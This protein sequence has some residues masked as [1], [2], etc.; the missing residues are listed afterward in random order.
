MSAFVVL[1]I[2]FV[3]L[4]YWFKNFRYQNN[5]STSL[6]PVLVEEKELKESYV[7]AS[8]SEPVSLEIPSINLTAQFENPLGLAPDGSVMV[9]ESFE[10]VGWYKYGPTPGERGPAVII[11]HVDSYEG[12]AVFYSLGQVAVGGVVLV[13]REDGSTV[14]FSIT[15][16]E[17][18]PQDEFPSEKVYGNL[19]NAGIRLVTCTGTYDREV[20]RYTH[21]LIVYGTLISVTYPETL[22]NRNTTEE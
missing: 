16:Y 19:P 10:T 8:S 20:K 3:I 11:G 4:G 14:T 15:G 1:A 18:V 5:I 12:P 2:S 6:N 21:N 9:P 22:E 7:L 13:T 17:R